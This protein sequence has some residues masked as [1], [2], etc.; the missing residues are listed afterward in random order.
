[1]DLLSQLNRA[2]AFV[3]EHIC[4]DLAL[5]DVCAVTA[6]SAYHFGR[7]FYYIAEVPLSEYLRRR[8]LSLAAMELQG[9]RARVLDLAVKYGYD[10]A[11]SFTRA[12]V[13]QHG[14]TPT[15]ARIAGATLKIFSPLVFHIKIRGVQEMNWR[16]EQKEAFDMFGIE[17]IFKNEESENIPAFWDEAYRD[18]SSA[19]LCKQAGRNDLM[20]LCGHVDASANEFPYMICLPAGKDCDT[21]G[22]KTVRVPEAAWAVFRSEEMDTNAYG[23]KIPG[24]F[25]RAYS[26]WLPSSGYDKAPS[27]DMEIYGVTGGGKYFEEVWIPVLKK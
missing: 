20:G 17:R 15:A 27:P 24:L 1:M 16:I 26:E 7:L 3:E 4:D 2:M 11:D 8:K 14:I 10:S 18:G 19:R 23:G 5:A 22:F 6:Y 25:Q 13:R 12:F 9:G 21:H